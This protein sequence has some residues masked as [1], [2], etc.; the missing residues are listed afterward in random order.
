M[1]IPSE[2]RSLMPTVQS[3]TPSIDVLTSPVTWLP[4]AGVYR[5]ELTD[6][7]SSYQHM[8]NAVGGY[9]SATFTIHGTREEIEEWIVTGLGRHVVVKD[10]SG[11]I[12]WE[13][14]VDSLT[15]ALGGLSLKRGPLINVGNYVN[16]IYSTIDT[17]ADPPIMG[18]RA[19]TGYTSD[20]DSQALYSVLETMLSSG[21]ATEATAEKAR[22][23]W[24]AERALPKTTQTLNLGGQS[25]ASVNVRCLGYVHLLKKFTYYN[26]TTGLDDADDKIQIV[27]QAQP[28]T[29]FEDTAFA[30]MDTNT[31]QVSLNE[32]DN[33]KAW[34][35][36][37]G[38]VALGDASNNRWTFGIY[39]DR[40]VYYN[41]APTSVNY[42][43]RVSDEEQIIETA[44]GDLVYPWN[45]L[46]AR[47]MR[48]V[49]ILIGR[50]PA[51]TSM[52]EDPRVLFIE[53]VTFTAP[54]GLSVTGGDTD[55]INQRL[56]KMGLAGVGG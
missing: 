9:W 37:K 6:N 35:I 17:N 25:P 45:V 49:D 15:A 47:W 21:G 19:R 1:I 46:P 5:G 36:I 41:Q 7:L 20:T 51:S 31:V 2:Y 33:R 34:D 8:L 13:G 22:D 26:R 16:L 56:A 43:H 11:S 53:S 42:V 44:D 29:I 12:I 30:N 48:F 23:N 18:V 14:F 10:Y 52:R 24:I 28:N 50:I 32:T 54:W 55:T 39:Q 4:Y 27:I 38:I 40:E 3:W